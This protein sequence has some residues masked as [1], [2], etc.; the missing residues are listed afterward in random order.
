[1]YTVGYI[2]QR[3]HMA[4]WETDKSRPLCCSSFNLVGKA[5]LVKRERVR[6]YMSEGLRCLMD[7]ALVLSLSVSC[8]SIYGALPSSRRPSFTFF[9]ALQ[10][11]TASVQRRRHISPRVGIDANQKPQKKRLGE[12]AWESTLVSDGRT[13]SLS[14]YRENNYTIIKKKKGRAQMQQQSFALE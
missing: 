3:P 2:S 7:Y 12:G 5:E 14:S 13:N 6:V 1:M 11:R 10:E 4:Q 8:P 9:Y